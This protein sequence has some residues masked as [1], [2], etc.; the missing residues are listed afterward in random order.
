M[1]VCA[2]ASPQS[3]TAH[4]A[5]PMIHRV[6]A[7]IC[8]RARRTPNKKLIASGPSIFESGTLVH[9][10]TLLPLST[11][12]LRKQDDMRVRT[13]HEKPAG[14]SLDSSQTFT[15]QLHDTHMYNHC[16]K[17]T[18]AGL[19]SLVSVCLDRSLQELSGLTRPTPEHYMYRTC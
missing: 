16:V 12:L 9:C 10:Y 3:S 14:H 5:T 17:Q 1:C 18:T 2:V 15:S 6:T 8:T 11:A 19:P 4:T 13:G 7:A